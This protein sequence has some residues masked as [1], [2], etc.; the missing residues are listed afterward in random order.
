MAETTS[1]CSAGYDDVAKFIGGIAGPTAFE[2]FGL[3]GAGTD[4]YDENFTQFTTEITDSGLARADSSHVGDSPSVD[5]HTLA[6]ERKFTATASKAVY[7]WALFNSST[8]SGSH[9]LMCYQFAS[10]QAMEA[11]DTLTCK[12]EI[13]VQAGT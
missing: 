7:G 10:S 11:N 1:M 4:T 6:V 9:A 5:S 13:T 8:V 2:W 3:D 12:T